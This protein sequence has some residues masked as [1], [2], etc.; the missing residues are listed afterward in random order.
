MKKNIDDIDFN[1]NDSYPLKFNYESLYGKEICYGEID[2]DRIILEFSDGT[3]VKI[4]D[5]AEYCCETRYITCDDD[6]KVLFGQKL[7]N[8]KIKNYTCKSNSCHN[9]HEEVFIDIQTDQD[10]ITF[11]SHNEHNGYYSGFDLCIVELDKKI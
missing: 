11:T 10:C 2:S 4:F 7:V 1:Q 5:D 8:F 9:D 3:R 6:I